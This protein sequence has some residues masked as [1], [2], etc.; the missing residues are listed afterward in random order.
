MAS[1]VQPTLLRRMN[2]RAVLEVIRTRGPSSRAEVTRHSGISAPTVSKA[3]AALLEARLL[4]EGDAQETSLGRP[5]K[6]LRLATESIQVLGAVIDVQR[7]WIGSAGLDGQLRDQPAESFATPGTYEGLI[8][9]IVQRVEAFLR[10]RQVPALGLGVSIPGL[11]QHSVGRSVFSPNLHQTDG[12][13][14]ARDLSERLGM[15]VVL[16]QES[17]ALCL[18]EWHYGAARG[19]ENF[20]MVDLSAG[21]G[22]GVISGGQVLTGASGMAG[23]LGHITVDPHGRL[24]GCGNHGCLET[25]A[26]DRAV[27]EAISQRT[28]QSLDIEEVV[29]RVQRGELQ[30]ARELQQALEYLAVG[31]AAVINL[32]NPSALFLHGR[33]LDAQEGLFGQLLE[34]TR[35]RTLGPSLD[36]CRIVRARGNKRQ[37]AVAGIINHL[38]SSLGPTL[39]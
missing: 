12:R 4:E 15:E 17:H 32:F 13:W 9:A 11:V 26:T 39:G 3:V 33:F 2:E 20:A 22:L 38:T 28:G 5:G 21:L 29:R 37:G 7:C 31:I 1:K 10:A 19:L 34:V 30:P 27:A 25:V 35:R 6:I 14:P 23:E 16:V 36:D 24:C 8:D 18:A